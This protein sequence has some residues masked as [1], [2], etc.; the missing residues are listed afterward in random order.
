MEGTRR[1]RESARKIFERSARSGQSTTRVHNE[2]RVQEEQAESESG[3][4]RCKVR[5]Q[6][7]LK[8]RVQD[9]DGMVER[10]EKQQGEERE[11]LP[12]EQICQTIS[13]KIKS[14]TKM[15]MS[16]R[17]KDIDKQE[18]RERIKESRYNRKYE[19]C[20]TEEIPEYMGRETAKE[21]K[22][23]ATVKCGNDER[24]NR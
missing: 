22:M 12:E 10:K 2:G 20:M 9:A 5:R 23:M 4:E 14:K 1:G 3:K 21:R 18:R 11:V 7:G 13:R 24:E 6:N 19:R 8:G 17:D 16:E 15:E